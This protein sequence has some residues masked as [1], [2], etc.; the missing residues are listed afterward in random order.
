[1]IDKGLSK[2]LYANIDCPELRDNYNCVNN[3]RTR[4]IEGSEVS[5]L[6]LEW[7]KEK[8]REVLDELT[9]KEKKKGEIKHLE[10]LG[11]FLK[12]ITSE[13][14]ELLEEENILKASFKPD[15]N[16]VGLVETPT[17]KPGYGN[18]GE[19]K[20]KGGG[21]R[22]GG[23]EEKEAGSEPK[24]SKSK[25]QILLSN[26]DPDPLN[27]GKTF[28]MIEREPVLHQRVEDVDYGIWWIN[29]QKSYIKKI[30]I[31]DPGAM[32]F[33]FFLVKEVVLSHRTRRLFREQERYDPDGIE[34]LNFLL[35][36]EIFNR[37]A[38]KLGIELSTDQT[39]ANKIREAIKSKNEFTASALADEINVNPMY[40]NTFISDHSNGV[41]ENFSQTKDGIRYIYTR[42]SSN[43]KV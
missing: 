38:Q 7:C 6:F 35:I 36:D 18:Q 33:Y 31:K 42:K 9:N 22:L 3:D 24:K 11:S 13:I 29:T 4:L 40:I 32:Q 26:H 39:I 25:L 27:P 5:D 2:S 23:K 37:V 21:S 43:S 1:L 15:S 8:L 16:A 12:E 14:S 10:E 20:H 19:I 41:L 34:E 30:N 17:N 28:D